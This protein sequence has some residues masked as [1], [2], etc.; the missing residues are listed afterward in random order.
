MIF[1]EKN[2]RLCKGG[3]GGRGISCRLCAA[4]ERDSGRRACC[5]DIG[6]RHMPSVLCRRY[7]V[8]NVVLGKPPHTTNLKLFLLFNYTIIIVDHFMYQAYTFFIKYLDFKFCSVIS[9]IVTW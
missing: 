8:H 7:P 1:V 3:G 2:I 9:N 6:F 5:L 4:R